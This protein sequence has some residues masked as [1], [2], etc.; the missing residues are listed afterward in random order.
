VPAGRPVRARGWPDEQRL[1]S[2]ENLL[3]L[4]QAKG[5]AEEETQRWAQLREL[6]QPQL[7]LVVPAEADSTVPETGG[8]AATRQT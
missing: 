3:F 1:I 4:L 2:E 6:A 8:S 5:L 7:G